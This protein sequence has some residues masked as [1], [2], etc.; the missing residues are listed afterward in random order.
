M[1]CFFSGHLVLKSTTRSDRTWNDFNILRK[2]VA[3]YFHSQASDLMIWHVPNNVRLNSMSDKAFYKYYTNTSFLKK[4]GSTLQSMFAKYVPLK[5]VAMKGKYV[6]VVNM[7]LLIFIF[8][9]VLQK[10]KY[11]SFK[12]KTKVNFYLRLTDTVRW[13]FQTLVICNGQIRNQVTFPLKDTCLENQ[14]CFQSKW[15]TND[16]YRLV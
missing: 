16:F 9:L 5:R 6:H 2:D 11:N 4:Y 8:S 7:F 13:I 15:Q 12:L 10:R 3:K 1:T 14:L